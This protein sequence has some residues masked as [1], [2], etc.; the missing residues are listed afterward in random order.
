MSSMMMNPVSAIE[1][2]WVTWFVSWW[3]AAVWSNRTVTRPPARREIPYSIMAIAGVTLLAGLYRHRFSS[4][5]VLWHAGLKFG[6]TMVAIAVAGFLFTWWARIVLGS[7]WSGGVRLK[8][9]HRIVDKGPY[10][11]VRHP[12]YTG[13][14]VAAFATAALRGTAMGLLGATLITIS[15]YIKAR[16]EERFL[17]EQL[18]ADIYD[19]YAR[20]VPMLVPFFN[21]NRIP[22][23]LP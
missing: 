5:F 12:I 17:R 20:G 19:A 6:W 4:E 23:K 16:I 22:F 7:L 11:L 15:F 3:A 18:G 1:I 2:A 13:V 8:V 21:V 14:I 10:R 9:D